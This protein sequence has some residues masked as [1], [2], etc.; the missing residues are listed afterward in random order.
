[1]IG[2]VPTN[3]TSMECNVFFFSSKRKK[4]K[5]K[6]TISKKNCNLSTFI[7]FI[8]F[9]SGFS[10]FVSNYGSNEGMERMRRCFRS[11]NELL[12]K[13]WS[14][15]HYFWLPLHAKPPETCNL[16]LLRLVGFRAKWLNERLLLFG[17]SNN[18]FRFCCIVHLSTKTMLWNKVLGRPRSFFRFIRK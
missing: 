4:I 2:S 9:I 18:D 10:W 16:V 12:R 6:R 3:V 8:V 7:G 17:N 1:M 14:N 13:I 15:Q 5:Q 11:I